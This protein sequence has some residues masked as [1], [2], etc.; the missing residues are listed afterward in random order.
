[1]KLPQLRPQKVIKA[2]RKIGF[3]DARQSG[4]HLI[5]VNRATKQIIPIPIHNKDLKKGLLSAIIKET[6]LTLEKFLKLL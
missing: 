3:D 2:L 4:S 1:M 6:S 5:L